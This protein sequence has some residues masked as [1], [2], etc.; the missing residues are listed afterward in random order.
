MIK[1]GRFVFAYQLMASFLP[2]ASLDWKNTSLEIGQD[3]L[4][5]PLDRLYSTI[6]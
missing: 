5:V 4:L 6:L 2:S 3:R 1:R